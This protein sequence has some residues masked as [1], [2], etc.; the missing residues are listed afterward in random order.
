[1]TGR[2]NEYS[3]LVGRRLHGCFGGTDRENFTLGSI[4]VGDIEIE[5]R[6][7]RKTDRP[8]GPLMVDVALEPDVASQ[9][10][11]VVAF[12]TALPQPPIWRR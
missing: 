6:L 12:K 5:M 2:V 3:P 1:M 4:E 9:S 7:L 8:A 10:A 11:G